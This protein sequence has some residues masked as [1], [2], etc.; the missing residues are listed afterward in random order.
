MG[1][2]IRLIVDA[3]VLVGELLRVRG[4]ALLTSASLDLAMTD[5]VWGE[6]Q[7]ELRRRL[8][9]QVAAGRMLQETADDFLALAE[10]LVDAYI[11]VVPSQA[12]AVEEETAR[13]RIP[14]DLADWPT[15]AVAL[16]FERAIWT[17]DHDFLGC[18]VPTWTT[19][20]L[21]AELAAH[22]IP[23]T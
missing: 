8:V 1:V 4:R 2:L 12:Y 7:H 21:L 16:A 17:Q 10:Q 5:V 18:G 11:I 22:G 13:R 23:A 15:V 6:A 3:S 19:T 20:T 14:T 9:A